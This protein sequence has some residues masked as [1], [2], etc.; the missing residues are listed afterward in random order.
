MSGDNSEIGWAGVGSGLLTMCTLCRAPHPHPAE[1]LGASQLCIPRLPAGW[2]P[3]EC[4][5][6]PLQPVQEQEPSSSCGGCPAGIHMTVQH[7]LL[8]AAWGFEHL[9][10][11][12]QGCCDVRNYNLA[13]LLVWL[14]VVFHPY[15][16]SVYV[17]CNSWYSSSKHKFGLKVHNKVALRTSHYVS[18]ALL[19]NLSGRFEPYNLITIA[20]PCSHRWA[21]SGTV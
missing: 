12:H 16:L 2:L 1:V 9:L 20:Y 18:L 3:E 21:F 15:P 7:F 17:G 6:D 8:T 11:D 19:I 4:H 10:C 5:L 13:A 14:I